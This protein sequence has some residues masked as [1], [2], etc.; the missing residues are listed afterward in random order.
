MVLRL[1]SPGVSCVQAK[2]SPNL[3]GQIVDKLKI[4]NKIGVFVTFLISTKFHSIIFVLN[5]QIF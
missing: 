4:L 1:K 2:L 5:D 3:F